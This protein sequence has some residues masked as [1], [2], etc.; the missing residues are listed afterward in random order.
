MVHV[1]FI[2]HPLGLDEI[3]CTGDDEQLGYWF[4]A[5]YIPPLGQYESE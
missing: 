5:M 4:V 2:I 3:Y 1:L